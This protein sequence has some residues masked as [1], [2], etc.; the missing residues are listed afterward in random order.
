MRAVT[1]VLLLS[2]GLAP[3]PLQRFEFSEPHMGTS[4]RV[5]LYA[6]DEGQA[7]GAAAAAF[8]RIAELDARLSDYRETSELMD[9]CRHAGGAPV[10]VSEDVFTVLSAARSFAIGTDGAFDVTI[11][12]V[13]HLWRRARAIGEL[14]DAGRLAEAARLVGYRK[15]HLAAAGRTVALEREGMLL[16]LGGI[17]KGYAAGEALKEIEAR[18]LHRALVALGGDIVVSEPPPATRG[19]TIAVASFGANGGTSDRPL[20]LSKAAVSTS[21]DAEQHLDVDGTRYSHIVDPATGGARATSRAVTVVAPQ[22]M[23]ADA[24]ATSVKLL[25]R[26]RGLALV[27]RTPGAAALVVEDTAAG[28]REYETQRWRNPEMVNGRW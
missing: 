19:W 10:R 17:A 15:M 13:T 18:G 27:E 11:G 1:T 2:A 26:S 3:Q 12:P 16:D 28:R 25:D 14:P 5:I 24:L 20:V 7:R 21:G 4:A 23:I 6:P 9:V 8:A 22:P